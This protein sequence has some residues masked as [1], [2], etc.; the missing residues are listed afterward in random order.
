MGTRFSGASTTGSA[1]DAPAILLW[2]AWLILALVLGCAGTKSDDAADSARNRVS[3]GHH[4]ATSLHLKKINDLG[5]HWFRTGGRITVYLHDPAASGETLRALVPHLAALPEL[6]TLRLTHTQWDDGAAALLRSLR[7]LTAL[8]LGDSVITDRALESIGSL[9]TLVELNLDDTDV[10]D[11]GLPH[12]K[13]LASLRSLSLAG[14]RVGDEGAAHLTALAGLRELNLSQ[15][16]VTDAAIARLA[17]LRQ[18][19]RLRIFGTRISDDGV[20][21]LRQAR[22]TLLIIR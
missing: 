10:T 12:L 18:L 19:E 17:E 13:S 21:R 8:D 7:H 4:A 5:G 2:Q 3:A 22:P 9:S 11:A 6:K 16:Q 1:R 14:T 20:A 15:T